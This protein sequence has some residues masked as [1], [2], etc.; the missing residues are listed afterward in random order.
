MS[1]T[2]KDYKIESL[3]LRLFL[4][5]IKKHNMY[6]NFRCS[7]NLSR[8]NR[9]FFHIM[10]KRG[11]AL[12]KHWMDRL[13]MMHSQFLNCS[14]CR[15]I[16]ETIRQM[17]GGSIK[18]ENTAKGQMKLMN[19]VNALI[20]S[21]IEFS[22][23]DTKDLTVLEKLGEEIYNDVCL[24]LF[25][26]EFVDQT[27]E[28]AKPNQGELGNMMPPT[29]PRVFANEEE[30]RRF[31]DEVIRKCRS[32]QRNNDALLMPP[33]MEHG[34]MYFQ[35]PFGDEYDEDYCEMLWG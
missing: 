3:I 35:Y 10:N 14:N 25:G 9:D 13:A 28:M 5:G 7:V 33:P 20:H 24:T 11:N 6:S 22:V 23:I 17:N 32:M 19:V 31:V 1:K 21:C 27:E 29:M 4:K 16:L 34:D 15:D 30:Y 12:Y 26:D 2:N 18:A 8:N